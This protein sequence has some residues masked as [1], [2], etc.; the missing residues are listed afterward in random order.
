[1]ARIRIDT[2]G[3]GQHPSEVMVTVNTKEGTETLIVDRRSVQSDTIDV[4]YPIGSEGDYLLVELPRETMRGEWR[5]LV[6]K[7]ILKEDAVA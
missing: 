4:G 7:T 2:V 5:V 3:Q 6:P 1:M